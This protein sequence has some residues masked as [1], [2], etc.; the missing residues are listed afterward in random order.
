M[1]VCVHACVRAGVTQLMQ[2]HFSAV[3]CKS[4]D[5]RLHTMEEEMKSRSPLAQRG[6]PRR[7]RPPWRQHSR[8]RCQPPPG[9]RANCP[10]SP[11]LPS[12]R[13]NTASKY[14]WGTDQ[15][16]G[17]RVTLPSHCGWAEGKEDPAHRGASA[18]PVSTAGHRD[19]DGL[20]LVSNRTNGQAPGCVPIILRIWETEAGGSQVQGQPG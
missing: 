8:R 20:E 6:G 18:S 13:S 12:G 10:C 5:A 4:E 17:D 7:R 14:R 19:R 15:P 16:G 3:K 1:C 11:G 9:H 2:N